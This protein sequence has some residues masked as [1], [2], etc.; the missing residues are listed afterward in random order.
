MG[1]DYDIPFNLEV[2]FVFQLS[3]KYLLVFRK[4]DNHSGGEINKKLLLNQE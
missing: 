2:E 4:K 3:Y 1:L